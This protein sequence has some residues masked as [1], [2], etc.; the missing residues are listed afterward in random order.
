VAAL[1]LVMAADDDD[2]DDEAAMTGRRYIGRDIIVRD[3]VVHVCSL[4][5]AMCIFYCLTIL[6]STL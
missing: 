1:A 4:V 6:L 3:D 2:D 5:L